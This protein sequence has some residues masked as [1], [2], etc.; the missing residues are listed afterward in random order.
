MPKFNI[1][2][3]EVIERVY[4]GIEIDAFGPEQAED[5]ARSLDLSVLTPTFVDPVELHV[6]ADLA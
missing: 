1:T 2:I 3:V 4:E 6:E 5:A